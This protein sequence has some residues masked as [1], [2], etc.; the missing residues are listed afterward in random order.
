MLGFDFYNETVTPCVIIT[1]F[2]FYIKI[3]LLVYIYLP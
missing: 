2:D 3:Y 1:G